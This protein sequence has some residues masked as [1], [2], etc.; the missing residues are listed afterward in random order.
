MQSK[1]IKA[2]ECMKYITTQEAAAIY[3]KSPRTIARHAKEG[4]LPGA[5]L[6]GHSWLVPAQPISEQ[7]FR[8]SEAKAPEQEFRFPLYHYSASFTRRWELRPLEQQLYDGQLLWLQGDFA[9]A[10]AKMQALLPQLKE[11]PLYLQ[12]GALYTLAVLA[13]D[14]AD[15]RSFTLYKHRIE[16]I[17]QQDFP[18]KKEMELYQP[19]F[20]NIYRGQEG[21][22]QF[23]PDRYYAYHPDTRGLLLLLQF[24]KLALYANGKRQPPGLAFYECHLNSLEQEGRYMLATMLHL[25][26]TYLYIMHGDKENANRHLQQG[27][28]LCVKNGCLT[29]SLEFI[30]A[31]GTGFVKALAAY[32]KETRVRVNELY[33]KYLNGL[34]ALADYENQTSIFRILDINDIYLVFAITN[35]LTNEAIAE[36]SGISHWTVSKKISALLQKIGLQRRS[37]IK[38]FVN[39]M[40]KTIYEHEF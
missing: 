7:E 3:G 6:H 33:R 11:E 8:L 17:M 22:L 4:R 39:R 29:L 27:L 9:L 24:L 19:I 21:L 2:G 31:M 15:I 5:V 36:F 16:T 25:L 13:I 35:G 38:D 23:E 30:F 37:E 32:N 40:N 28:E 18:Y 12:L 26:F 20:T 1:F 10:Y 14:N 34:V